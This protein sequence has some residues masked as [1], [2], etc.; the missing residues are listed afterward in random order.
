MGDSVDLDDEASKY[1]N[2]RGE[3][4]SPSVCGLVRRIQRLTHQPLPKVYRPR[5]DD[6]PT[7]SGH[8]HWGD[9][10]ECQRGVSVAACVIGE[11]ITVPSSSAWTWMY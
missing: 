4:P 10:N 3:W 9:W 6:D 8:L 1:A 7:R 11:S 2:R 5:S